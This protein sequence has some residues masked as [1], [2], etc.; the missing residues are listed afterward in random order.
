VTA[1]ASTDKSATKTDGSHTYLKGSR[2]GYY[3]NASGGKVY[4]DHKYCQQ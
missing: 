1:T 3:L 2:G 4:V